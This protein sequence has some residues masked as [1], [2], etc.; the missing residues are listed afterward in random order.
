MACN[1]YHLLYSHLE[2]IPGKPGFRY[3]ILVGGLNTNTGGLS[4]KIVWIMGDSESALVITY[5]FVPWIFPSTNIFCFYNEN[6]MKN[7]F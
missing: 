5:D 6:R 2:L 4:K 3:I 1:T 7:T